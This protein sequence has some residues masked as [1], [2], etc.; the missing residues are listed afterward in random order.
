MRIGL[1]GQIQGIVER[2]RRDERQEV[3]MRDKKQKVG[4][5]EERREEEWTEKRV[6]RLEQ[7]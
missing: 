2:G 7:W 6:K 5:E 4:R 3:G 1:T